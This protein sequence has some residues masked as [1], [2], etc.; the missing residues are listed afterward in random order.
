MKAKSHRFTG[1]LPMALR[2]G[3]RQSDE[4][5]GRYAR[6][7]LSEKKAPFIGGAITRT[8]AFL[9]SGDRQQ[10]LRTA[11]AALDEIPDDPDLLCLIGT[12][13]SKIG[14]VAKAD[15][16]FQAAYRK[17]CRCNSYADHN[18]GGK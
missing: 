7:K 2:R 17:E 6:P 12:V 3:R 10:A 13:Y 1:M 9:N 8:I 11:K 16:S 15:E 18:L 14:D 4:L 5:F